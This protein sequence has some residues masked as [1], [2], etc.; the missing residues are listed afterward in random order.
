MTVL[1]L[2]AQQLADRWQV[3]AS[4][5]YRLTRAGT[6]PA[7]R[8]GRYYRYS[9]TAIEAFEAGEPPDHRTASGGQ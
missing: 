4:Q 6:I 2:T 8:L 1:L 3:P 5:V 7:V 9:P